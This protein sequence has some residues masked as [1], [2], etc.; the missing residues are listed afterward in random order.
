MYEKA[1]KVFVESIPSKQTDW[2]RN[3]FDGKKEVDRVWL[4]TPDFVLVP[5]FKMDMTN[6]LS[7]YIQ[8]IFKDAELKSVRNLTGN[9]LPLLRNARQAILKEAAKRH[10]VKENELR[11]YFHYYPTFWILHLH[12]TPLKFWVPGGGMNVGR[13]ILLDDVIQNLELKSDYYQQATLTT[14][15][16]FGTPHHQSFVDAEVEL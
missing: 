16:K 7:L 12:I 10:E 4:N 1:T 2:V 8:C 5:D 15:I 11:L 13:A 9:H 6:P 14:S 3:I